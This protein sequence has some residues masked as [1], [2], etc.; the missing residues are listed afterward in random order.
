MTP[1]GEPPLAV[2]PDVP[3]VVLDQLLDESLVVVVDEPMGPDGPG[4]VVGVVELDEVVGDEQ[5]RDPDLG[6]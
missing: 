5:D 2:D 6:E 3:V 1:T 4:R